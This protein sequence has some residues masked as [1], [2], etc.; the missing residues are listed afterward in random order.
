MFIATYTVL[1]RQI[2]S[3]VQIAKVWGELRKEAVE[4]L[5]VM[6]SFK[7][8]IR[9][10]SVHTETGVAHPTFWQDRR[11]DDFPSSIPIFWFWSVAFVAFVLGG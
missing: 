11:V 4:F 3:A 8:Q 1:D 5:S 6:S 10:T 2:S 9:Q 7:E